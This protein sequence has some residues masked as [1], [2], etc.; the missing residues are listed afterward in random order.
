MHTGIHSRRLPLRSG[1]EQDVISKHRHVHIWAKRPGVSA[2]VKRQVR[3][4]E[5]QAGKAELKNLN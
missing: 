5:R 3:R 1:A 2:K 4:H